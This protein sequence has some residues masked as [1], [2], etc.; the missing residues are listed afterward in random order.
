M[1]WFSSFLHPGRGYKAGQKELDKYYNQGQGFLNPYNQQGQAQYGNLN[2]MIQEL[3]NP[4]ALQD[5]WIKGYN[6]SE[7]SKNARGMAQEHGL[8]AASSMGLMGSSPALQAIQAGTSAISSEDRQSYLNDLMQKYMQ[9]IGASQGI[10]GTG[11]GA[12]GQMGQNA[13]N[14]GQ[15]SA[16]MAYGQKNAGGNMLG[17]LIGA[18]LGLGGSYLAGRNNNRPW[19]TGG[20]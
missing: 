4:G 11:A 18:G 19:T 8:D 5:K 14:M 1:S 2:Q 10:Y 13:M 16:N 15:N 17:G 12:A 6:E 7:A 3:M 9:A 20:S